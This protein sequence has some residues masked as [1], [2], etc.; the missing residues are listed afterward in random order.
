MLRK[1][2][3]IIITVLFLP[4]CFAAGIAFYEEI[5]GI[6]TLSKDQLYFFYGCVSYILFHTIAFKPE[7]VY[8][9]GHEMMHAVAAIL[10]G[11]RVS[12]FKV[13][14]AGGSV[15]T[16]KSNAFISL[17]PYLFPFYTILTAILYF[18]LLHFTNSAVL[19]S[20]LFLFFIGFTLTF[21]IVLTIDFLKIKQ[22]DLLGTGYV[23]SIELIYFINLLIIAFIFSLLFKEIEFKRFIYSMLVESKQSYIFIFKQLFM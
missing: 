23:F 12:S 6:N 10:S 1:I 17:A 2:I 3:H 16:N 5:G 7:R 9:F 4:V 18:A 22:T 21:H 15:T 13:S 11:G 8:I 19:F 14:K 20:K